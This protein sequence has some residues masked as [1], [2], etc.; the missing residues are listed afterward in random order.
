MNST[1]KITSAI[2]VPYLAKI[3][4]KLHPLALTK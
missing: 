4:E 1:L 3:G 2:R